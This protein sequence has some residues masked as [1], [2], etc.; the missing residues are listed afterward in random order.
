[1]QIEEDHPVI[2]VSAPSILRLPKSTIEL[3]PGLWL[4]ARRAVWLPESGTL[5]VADLHLGYAWSHR[6]TGNLLPIGGDDPIGR[7]RLLVDD[8][9]AREVV[10]IGDVVHGFTAPAP[11]RDELRRLGAEIGGRARLRLLAGNHDQWLPEL[12]AEAGLADAV[13]EELFVGPH[14]LLHGHRGEAAAARLASVRMA[15]GRV[16]LGHEHPS[17]NL[18]DG[19]ATRSRCPCFLVADDA[20]VLP[21]FSAWA[22]GTDIRSGE[23]MSP[24]ARAAKFDRIA[25][26]VAGKLL[27]L[28]L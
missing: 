2:R 1:M 17:I 28:P 6:A 7:L 14:L 23:F 26:I 21:A 24:Y 19:V 22:S 15:G 25:A 18:S 12:I 8:Y 4:D 16:I 13:E 10:V 11:V 5:G 20:L 9:Q 27:P 3:A